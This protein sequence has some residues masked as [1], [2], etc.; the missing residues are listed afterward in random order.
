MDQ[1]TSWLSLE[2]LLGWGTSVQAVHKCAHPTEMLQT[3]VAL[4]RQKKSSFR[5]DPGT[6]KWEFWKKTAFEL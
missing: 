4:K 6:P 5:L 2:K 3:S 1:G